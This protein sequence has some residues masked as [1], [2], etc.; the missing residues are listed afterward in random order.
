METIRPTS[1]AVLWGGSVAVHCYGARHGDWAIKSWDRDEAEALNP[2]IADRVERVARDRGAGRLYLPSPNRF[3]G[4]LVVADALKVAWPGDRVFRGAY[5]EGVT[6]EKISDA[7]GIASSDCPT[8][9]AR[10]PSTLLVAAAHAGRESLYDAKALFDGAPPRPHDSVTRSIVEALGRDIDVF[11]ACGI[12]PDEFLHP[13]DD[14][15]HGARNAAMIRRLR[16]TWGPSCA[17]DDRAGRIDLV[18]LI[19]RQF[20]ALGVPR[21]RVAHDGA[22]T[23]GDAALDGTPIWHSHRRDKGGKRN[24]VLVIRRS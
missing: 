2:G 4:E 12:G 19:R 10:N 24:F 15:K 14:P 22:D 6:L 11:V 16:E 20:E 18:E 1:T 5:A 9:V 17:S 13:T 7:C 8:I 3:D 23:F 21:S